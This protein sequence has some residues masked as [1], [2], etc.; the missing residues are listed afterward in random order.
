MQKH[1]FPSE[2][3]YE[4]KVHHAVYARGDSRIVQDPNAGPAPTED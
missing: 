3:R 2:K 4:R 1:S